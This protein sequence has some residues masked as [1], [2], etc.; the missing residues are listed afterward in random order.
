MANLSRESAILFVLAYIFLQVVYTNSYSHFR[1]PTSIQ[2][3]HY[4]LKVITHMDNTA[5]FRYEGQISMRFRVLE[6]TNNITM[7]ALNLNI[8]N[9]SLVLSKVKDR[10]F[11]MCLEDIDILPEFDYF[12]MILCQTLIKDEIYRVQMKFSS[13]L[14]TKSNGYYRSSYKDA[15]TNETRWLSVTKFEPAFARA[16]FPCLDE[17]Q[18]K[19]RFTIWL[20]HHRSRTALSNMPREKQK[21]LED[22]HDYVW[23]IFEESVPMSTY[24]VAYSVNDFVY[25]ASSI[26]MYKLDLRTWSRQDSINKSGYVVEMAP[27]ILK[28]YEDVL[29][30]PYPLPKMDQIALPDFNKGGME[31]WGLVTYAEKVLY[32]DPNTRSPLDKLHTVRLMAHEF[33]HQW[34]GNLVTMKWWSDLWLNEGFATYIASLCVEYI[35]PEFQAYITDSFFSLV[36]SFDKDVALNSRPLSQ[37]VFRT[38]EIRNRFDTISYRKGSAVLRMVHMILGND[39]FFEGVYDY[40]EKHKYSNANQD[41]LWYAFS[42]TANKCNNPLDM[43]TVM[44]SWSLQ[45]GFPLVKVNRNYQT[46]TIEITQH[47]FVQHNIFI[48]DDEIRKCWWIPLTYTTAG[49]K[50]FRTTKPR[51]WLQCNETQ[52][53]VPVIFDNVAKSNEWIIFNIQA[54]AVYKVMYDIH[55]WRLLSEALKREPLENFPI[56][57]RGQIVNDAISLAWNGYHGYDIAFDILEYL[58][59]EREYLPWALAMRGLANV[60]NFLK[61]FPI[62]YESFKSFI[63]HIIAPVFKH[64]NGFSTLNLANLLPFQYRLKS[65]VIQWACRVDLKDCIKASKNYF[66]RWALSQGLEYDEIFLKDLRDTVYCTAIRHG[67]INDWNSLWQRYLET[68]DSLFLEALACSRNETLIEDFISLIFSPEKQISNRETIHAFNAIVNS[69]VGLPLAWKYFFANFPRLC[70]DFEISHLAAELTLSIN[71]LNDLG[72]LMA[73]ANPGEEYCE[74]PL[75]ITN[76]S[77]E[78]IHF[79]IDWIKRNLDIIE[80]YLRNRLSTSRA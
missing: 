76:S 64:L 22:V 1:L 52:V 4:H 17:P 68:R 45:S 34:F 32:Y 80:A 78:N 74:F 46:G 60:C 8:D 36:S 41:D 53:G 3:E 69:E 39:A 10:E 6:A 9:T 75:K 43:K 73:F 79:R 61:A 42:K 14:N 7:H 30:I 47:R 26:E 59:K 12:I 55:N 57:N 29:G 67:T 63:R 51:Y 16:A 13:F 66:Q 50:N 25:K 28:Y 71:S 21:P 19:A 24:L 23:S 62:Q 72:D 70:K 65:I 48:P 38:S 56:L 11:H 40:L 49:E 33:A 54:S 35:H 20:G 15:A 2:P 18:Y 37:E 58:F 5:T 31:N 27:R 77:M 44:D